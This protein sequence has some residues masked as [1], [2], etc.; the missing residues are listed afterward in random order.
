MR[1][2]VVKI[3]RSLLGQ[4]KNWHINYH[5]PFLW[6]ISNCFNG[7]NI[8]LYYYIQVDD[9]SLDVDK[10]DYELTLTEREY[11]S[12]IIMSIISEKMAKSIKIE[13]TKLNKSVRKALKG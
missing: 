13:K 2:I 9:I 8:S 10:Y 7:V 12:A 1:N 4:Q 6:E 5:Y 11:L 3:G